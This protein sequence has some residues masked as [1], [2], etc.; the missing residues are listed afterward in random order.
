MTF[1]TILFLTILTLSGSALG[2]KGGY[3]YSEGV[4]QLFIE[5]AKNND[6]D[7]IKTL[8]DDYSDDGG[9]PGYKN[10]AM[11]YAA[12][13][14]HK[15]IV[16]YLLENGANISSCRD[17]L[18]AL[19]WASKNGHTEMVELLLEQGVGFDLRDLQNALMYADK[20]GH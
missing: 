9:I 20:N 18:T 15:D 19:E 11:V 16:E 2:K 8:L 4:E 6:L 5:A 12:R 10:G 14:G 7:E 3:Y 1:K 13:M 17:K